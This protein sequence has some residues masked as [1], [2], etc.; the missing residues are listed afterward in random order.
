MRSRRTFSRA[1]F[2]REAAEG[3]LLH[4]EHCAP[5]GR[6]KHRQGEKGN[7]GPL[8]PHDARVH[9]QYPGGALTTK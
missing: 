7:G 8:P 9:P 2:G 3:I 5:L 1:G 6:T 4:V